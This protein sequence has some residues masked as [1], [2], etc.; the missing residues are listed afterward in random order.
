MKSMLKLLAT[1]LV[2]FVLA[3]V[4]N[5]P[6]HEV[7]HYIAADSY[8]N[9]PEF[10]FF[11]KEEFV[12]ENGVQTSAAVLA[13]VSYFSDSIIFTNEDATIAFAGPFVNFLLAM[14]GIALFVAYRKKN[15]Y[16]NVGLMVFI[17]LSTVAFAS[18]LIPV[19]GSDGS[20]ILSV[21]G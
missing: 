6:L 10:H 14:L 18:N 1:A 12:N 13:Y 3:T 20:V 11:E 21:I 15:I 9:S 8:G 5:V 4:I 19:A 7:G 17:I 2:S 16:V